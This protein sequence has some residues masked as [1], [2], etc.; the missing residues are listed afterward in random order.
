MATPENLIAK[1]PH[2]TLII[3]GRE[4]KV[5]PPQNAQRLFELIPNAELHM[6]GRCGHW[7][8]IEHSDRFNML[9]DNF[10]S[11]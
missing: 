1:L 7:S 8:Q 4:D 9:V 11:A 2:P 10:C 3:H 5:I 6:F